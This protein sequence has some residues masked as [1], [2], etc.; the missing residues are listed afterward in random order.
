[1]SE[2]PT[3]LPDDSDALKATVRSLLLEHDAQKQRADDLHIENL[4]LQAESARYK[5]RY[6]GPRADRLQTDGEL[7]QMLPSFAEA[8]DRKPRIETA[9]KP[10]TTIDKGLAGP[11]LLSYIVTSKFAA[12]VPLYRLEDIFERQGFEI[13]RA[14]QSVRCGDVADLVEPLWEL[15]AD[16]VR[17]SHVVATDD[18]IMPML[19]REKCANARM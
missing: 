13:S 11:G 6:Y 16:Q 3:N 17:A 19:S 4:R 15:M 12:Y 14:T 7:A 1:V 2:A 8:Q 18:T 9:A 10:E 5:K